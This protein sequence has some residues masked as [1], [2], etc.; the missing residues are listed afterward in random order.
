MNHRFHNSVGGTAF[1]VRV[2]PRSAKNKIVEI[3][4]D[5]TV[6]IHLT[7]PPLEGKANRQLVEFLAETLQIKPS[8]I[9]IVG[10]EKSKNK[11][12]T[13]QGITPSVLEQMLRE[14]IL[15]K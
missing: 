7:A 10:G 6:R 2:V 8:Q 9:D 4:S 1:A 14:K 11:L 12:V 13:I 15:E 3:M 5:G